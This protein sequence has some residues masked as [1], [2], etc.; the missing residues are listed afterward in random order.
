M[1]PEGER[2]P[3][4]MT[5][6]GMHYSGT[7]GAL[8]CGLCSQGCLYILSNNYLMPNIHANLE[9]MPLTPN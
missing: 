2:E 3:N 8:S 7:G 6:G 1:G 4:S 9:F 5:L